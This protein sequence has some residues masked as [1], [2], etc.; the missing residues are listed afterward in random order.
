MRPLDET[1]DSWKPFA[2]GQL[3]HLTASLDARHRLRRGK[4]LINRAV[5]GMVV[6]AAVLLVLNVYT[7]GPLAPLSCAQCRTHFAEYRL[8]Q[9]GERP[10]D[11]AEL[12]ER[13]AAHLAHCDRCRAK[14][15]AAYPGAKLS[16]SAR[17]HAGYAVVAATLL[18]TP[19]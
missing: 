5:A 4:L 18:Q 10:M 7:R 8:H 2:P 14:F 1:S 6:A 16:A 19:F 17:V 3:A 12:A 11:D 15:L 9:T 13:M